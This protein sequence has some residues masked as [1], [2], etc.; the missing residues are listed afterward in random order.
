MK[1]LWNRKVAIAPTSKCFRSLFR[2]ARQNVIMQDISY[3]CSLEISGPISLISEGMS[4]LVKSGDLFHANPQ[5]N[6]EYLAHI[7]TLSSNY[8][9]P[10][11]YLWISDALPSHSKLLVWLHPTIKTNFIDDLISI[12]KLIEQSAELNFPEFPTKD[13]KKHLW[14]IVNNQRW[15]NESTL[16]SLKDLGGCFNR[17]RL[18]GPKTLSVL[19]GVLKIGTPSFE[20]TGLS[21][22]DT[23]EQQQS[24]WKRIEKIVNIPDS[25]VIPLN[26]IDPRWDLPDKR[27]RVSKERASD[28]LVEL[29]SDEEKAS[30]WYQVKMDSPLWQDD[31][32]RMILH[33]KTSEETLSKL[34][35]D[36]LI[37]G[38]TI[39]G[40]LDN[41]SRDVI[42][43]VLITRS[44]NCNFP[45]VDLILPCGW[46]M[47][48]WISLSYR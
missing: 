44:S 40:G 9:G 11:K 7:V 14:K 21:P 13:E 43:I 30:N 10:I 23:L 5:W 18:T 48:F 16:V 24:L 39:S 37:P 47:A 46:L 29:E 17:I 32:R 4:Q 33:N 35:S 8:L 42:P 27:R 22:D 41:K 15:M 6:K 26:V 25:T 20:E 38:T 2:A 31:K 28:S 1:P 36:N 19:K 45:G 3:M 34:R 12:F